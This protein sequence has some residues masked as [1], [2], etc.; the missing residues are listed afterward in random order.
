MIK[1]RKRKRTEKDKCSTYSVRS[2]SILFY[3]LLTFPLKNARA[4]YIFRFPSLSFLSLIFFLFPFF[5]LSFLPILLFLTNF[6]FHFLSLY[7]FSQLFSCVF[8]L[9]I[10]F[11]F[12]FNIFS[13]FRLISLHFPWFFPFTLFCYSHFY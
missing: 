10:I 7:F 1:G 2:F 5:F 4:R 9:L 11:I 3:S 12:L 8:S 13:L 6:S